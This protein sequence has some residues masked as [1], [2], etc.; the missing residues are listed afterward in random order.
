MESQ[1][2]EH[3]RFNKANELFQ[4]CGNKFSKFFPLKVFLFRCVFIHHL[5]FK[6]FDPILN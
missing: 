2:F 1:W 4:I 6:L 5:A 3:Q